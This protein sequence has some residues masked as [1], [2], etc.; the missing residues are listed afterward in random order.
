MQMQIIRFI[1]GDGPRGIFKP[2][3]WMTAVLSGKAAQIAVEMSG[4]PSGNIKGTLEMGTVEHQ[5]KKRGRVVGTRLAHLLET[6]PRACDLLALLLNFGA[7][8]LPLFLESRFL[9]SDEASRRSEL[10]EMLFCVR[11]ANRRS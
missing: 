10:G 4:A 6:E 5:S 8:R 9:P 7:L 3:K 11:R 2:W 1:P